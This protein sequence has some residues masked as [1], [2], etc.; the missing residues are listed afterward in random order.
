MPSE[1]KSAAS[2]SNGAKSKGPKSAETRAKSSRNSLKHGLT[3][4]NTILLACENPDEF[5]EMLDEYMAAHQPASAAETD[6]V[7]EMVAARWRIQRYWTIETVLL[8]SE[9]E[10]RGKC[11][12]EDESDHPAV[13]LGGR[14]PRASRRVPRP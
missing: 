12:P 7:H 3:S 14:L 13:Q 11:R 2:R 9:M 5:Q 1:R 6:F 10:N 4:T 8:N